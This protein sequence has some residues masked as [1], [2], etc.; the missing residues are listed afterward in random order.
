MTGMGA[1]LP[2]TPALNVDVKAT[3]RQAVRQERSRPIVEA[4]HDWLNQQL[5]RISKAT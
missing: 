1:K 3:Q 4:L 2:A 5:P